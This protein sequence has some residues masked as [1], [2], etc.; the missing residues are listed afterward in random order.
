MP[1]YTEI[2]LCPCLAR[3]RGGHQIILRRPAFRA[4]RIAQLPPGQ[5][6]GGLWAAD[7]FQHFP[8]TQGA[9]DLPGGAGVL[10]K[11]DAVQDDKEAIL[12]EMDFDA[13]LSNAC[14]DCLEGPNRPYI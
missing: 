7:H 5:V 4:V 1:L 11:V 10:A 13:W 8:L 12:A 3:R 9:N 14:V 2:R 6:I